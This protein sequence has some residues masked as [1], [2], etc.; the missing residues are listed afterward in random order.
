MKAKIAVAAVSL[1]LLLSGAQAGSRPAQDDP[2]LRPIEPDYA[3]RWLDPA[4]PVRVFGNSYMV[5][6]SG[7]G[8]GLIRTSKGLILLDGAVP[9][10]VRDVEANLR[11]LGFRI[12]DVKFILSTEP[13]YDHAGGLAALA[14]DSG[15]TVL[16]SAAAAKALAAGRTEADDPQHAILVPFPAVK[17]L[18]AVRDGEQ[19]RLGDTVVTAVA[20]PGH[21]AG[22]MSWRW[23]S[24]EGTRCLNVVFGSSVTAVSADD[25]R[26]TDHPAVVAPFRT[27]FTRFRVMPCDILLNTHPNYFGGDEKVSQIL[28]RR[29]PNPFVD[30]KAC[31]TYADKAEAAL[32]ERLAKEKAAR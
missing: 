32:D 28:R 21:T 15:A 18:R 29:V 1:A 11:K 22:S 16:A 8:V 7:L 19:I 10:A 2:L 17:R 30:A 9:Q 25:Y 12:Q 5:G 14:R 4:P 20:T 26:F 13:H 23:R 6:F 27:T 3:R 31:R 24:C